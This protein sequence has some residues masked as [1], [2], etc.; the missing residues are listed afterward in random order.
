MVML[1]VVVVSQAS[2]GGIT[3]HLLLEGTQRADKKL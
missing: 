1:A 2:E 3:R